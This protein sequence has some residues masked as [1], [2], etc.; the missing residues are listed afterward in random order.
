MSE[1]VSLDCVKVAIIG[2][3]GIG[4]DVDVI[5]QRAVRT[6]EELDDAEALVH[7]IEQGAIQVEAQLDAFSRRLGLPY[8]RIVHSLP[9]SGSTGIST[10]KPRV[11]P[12]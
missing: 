5:A 9:L 8:V 11:G 7:R 3:G 12:C 4:F 1:P 2:S 10:I 6:V